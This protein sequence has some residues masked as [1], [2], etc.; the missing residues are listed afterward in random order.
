MM[1]DQYIALCAHHPKSSHLPPPYI[2][3]P[4]PFTNCH[5][6]PS[7]IISFWNSYN[8]GIRLPEFLTLFLLLCSLVYFLGICFQLN[9]LNKSR[10]DFSNFSCHIFNHQEFLLV[11]WLSGYCLYLIYHFFLGTCLFLPATSFI[12]L[13]FLYLI[14]FCSFII[15]YVLYSFGLYSY[16]F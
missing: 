8:L 4:L 16:T 5:P 13:Y 2:W 9:L 3:P 6:L 12:D 7:S 11:F 14:N 15:Q 1:H 10:M